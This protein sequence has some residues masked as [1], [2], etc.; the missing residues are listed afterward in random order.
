MR[1]IA[2]IVLAI[3]LMS[4]TASAVWAVERFPPPDFTDHQLPQTTTP[5]GRWLGWEYVDVAALAAAGAEVTMPVEDQFWGDRWG[6]LRDPFGVKM[7]EAAAQGQWTGER[8]LH[9][10]LL[11]EQHADEQGEG[12]LDEELVRGVVPRDRDRRSGHGARG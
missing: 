11:V 5:G 6:Q 1:R 3:G 8:P 7:A 10:H 4:A 9:R 2:G 12:I